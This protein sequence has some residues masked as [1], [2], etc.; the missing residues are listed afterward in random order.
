M[1][2][3]ERVVVVSAEPTS[4]LV[5]AAEHV[6]ASWT[7]SA[8]AGTTGADI[9]P[10]VLAALVPDGEVASAATRAWVRAGARGSGRAGLF[11]GTSG[12]LAG[13]RLL[14]DRR[15]HAAQAAD[16]AAAALG[17]APPRWRTAAVGFDDYDVVGGP[18]GV[19]L[20]QL[21]GTRPVRPEHLVP[22]VTHLACLTATGFRIGAHAGHPLVGW[23]QGGVVTGL[24]HGVA[25][26]VAAL[27]M[28]L[29]HVPDA[30]IALWR[31]ASWLADQRFTDSRGVVSWPRRVP[32][33]AHDGEVRRQGWCY[34]TPG[35]AWALWAAGHALVHSGHTVGEELCA[36]ATEAVRT[37]CAA[38]DPGCHLDHDP[39]AVCHGAAGVLLV[40]DAFAR[41]TGSP[42]AAALRAEL[43]AY[44]TGR[45]EEVTRLDATLLSGASGVL[46]ALL[47]AAG[48][49]RGW[50]PCLALY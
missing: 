27:S 9:G 21:T 32:A 18:A 26:P 11:G 44:L 8:A 36:V 46:A 24:A 7:A 16:R 35:I 20:A 23:A 12:I 3:R 48:G 40:A 10:V 45:L 33:P 2:R 28:A 38:Y 25:G 5:G 29:P 47:T 34:G 41:H 50:L 37:L 30:R 15:P 42:A 19:L 13:L 1:S 17:N 22:A 14:A 49:D 31:L 39:L 6:L 43:A 4:E